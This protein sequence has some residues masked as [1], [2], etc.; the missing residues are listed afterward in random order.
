VTLRRLGVDPAVATG[1]FVTTAMD[2][3]GVTIYLG[4]AGAL[5]ARLGG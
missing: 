4:I 5:I 1:P 3:V 2:G